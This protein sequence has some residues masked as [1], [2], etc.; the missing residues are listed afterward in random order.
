M[1]GKVDIDFRKLVFRKTSVIESWILQSDAHVCGWPKNKKVNL[2]EIVLGIN[3]SLYKLGI[4]GLTW[5]VYYD[6]LWYL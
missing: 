5:H 4:E 2:V 3:I 6:Y 1:T